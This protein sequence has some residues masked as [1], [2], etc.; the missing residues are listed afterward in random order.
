MNSMNNSRKSENGSC[1]PGDTSVAPSMSFDL[2][3][4]ASGQM[5][6]IDVTGKRYE[7]VIPLRAFPISEPNG[8]IALLT[9]KGD[10]ILFLE[11][12]DSLP[13][14]VTEMIRKELTCR[15]FV[16]I[17]QRIRFLTDDINLPVW[18]LKTDRGST[19]VQVHVD[20]GLRRLGENGLLIVDIYGVRFLIPDINKLDYTSRRVLDR[21]L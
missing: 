7:G 12:L 18:R 15:E 21:Y 6:L 8:C 3:Y 5:V 10:E 17:I 1:V 19:Q 9:E 16:P 13:E 2:S 14:S 11:S 4:N 20:D